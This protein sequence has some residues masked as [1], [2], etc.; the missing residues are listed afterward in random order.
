MNHSCLT[1]LPSPL[2]SVTSICHLLLPYCQRGTVLCCAIANGCLIHCGHTSIWNAAPT[3]RWKVVLYRMGVSL[4]FCEVPEWH[5]RCKERVGEVARH[6][7]VSA[8]IGES[9]GFTRTKRK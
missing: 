9:K 6:R 5:L 4:T 8:G 7:K 2:R 3:L 1:R